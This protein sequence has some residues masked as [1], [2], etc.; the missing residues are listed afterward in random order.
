MATGK[1]RRMGTMR[2][3]GLTGTSQRRA[4]SRRRLPAAA[5]TLGG[6]ALASA[7]A[8][9]SEGGPGARSTARGTVSF[10]SQQ[11]G[12]VDQGRYK[13]VVDAFNAQGGPV[14]IELQE[15]GG[16]VAEVLQK[17]VTTVAADTAPT[18]GGTPGGWG[19]SWAS[20]TTPRTTRP[21]SSESCFTCPGARRA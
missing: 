14:Q 12:A 13:P 8:G 4:L 19:W 1:M 11:A 15:G 18:R 17:L 2:D 6:G 20:P 7:C 3:L 21:S 10:M 16:G 5:A 9:G